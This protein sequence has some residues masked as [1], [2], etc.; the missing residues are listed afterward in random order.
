MTKFSFTLSQ[1]PRITHIYHILLCLILS[2]SCNYANQ[3][4][5]SMNEDI[6][7][8]DTLEIATF[9]S[10]CFWCIEAIYQEV[11]GIEKVVSG[12]SGGHIKNPAYREVISGRTGHAEV[13]QIHFDPKIISYKE[14]LEIFWQ[15]HDP[16]TL[17]RQ[18]NDVGTQYRSII[19]YHNK[20]QKEQAEFYKNQLTK[21][22][23]FEDPI[24]TEIKAYEAFYPAD[25]Y[26]Q[27]FY[28]NNKY[29][30]YCTYVIKPKLEK[31]RKAF[32]EKIKP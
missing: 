15:T 13:A 14:L 28:E 23:A 22:N 18:G 6:S 2:T 27:D 11:V 12:F 20:E 19:L 7:P 16:T 1:S 3:I 30:G 32:A 29:Q 24:V 9:G 26:H 10:G 21:Q 17:N 8:S 4:D 31:F 25:E 5:K